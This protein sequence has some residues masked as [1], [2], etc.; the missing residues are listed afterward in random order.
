MRRI[1]ILGGGTAGTIMANRL[2]RALEPTRWE[3]VVIDGEPTHYYQPGFLFLPFGMYSRDDVV[4]P[5]L[6]FMPRGMKVVFTTAEAIEPADNRIHMADGSII[7][8]DYLIIATGSQVHPEETEGL[9]GEEWGHSIHEFYTLDGA[10]ALGELLGRWTGGRLVLNIAEMPIKCPVAPIEFLFLA[11]WWFTRR[12]MREKVELELVTPLPGAFTRPM[13]STVLGH[14]F[15]DKH[16]KLT[17]DFALAEVDGTAKQIKDWEGRSVAYDLLVSVPTN[18][19]DAVIARSGLGDD[20]NFVPT[21]P[22]TLQAKG[23]E[24]IYVLG[25][26]TDLPSSKAGSVAHFQSE[27]LT[28]NL[29]CAMRGAPPAASFDGHTN[30]FIESGYGK[31]ILVDFNY[32]TEP[33]PGKFPVPRLGPFTLLAESRINHWGKL[34]FRWIYWNLL[35]KGRSLLIPPRMSMAGKLPP[36]ALKKREA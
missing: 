36:P 24:N 30:C 14:M 1:V 7:E 20:L 34:G 16:I 2:H 31:A 26:A 13:C 8:Y 33:L 32:D 19:G 18:M 6:G 3:I 35:I 25:D 15:D 11:D 10:L 22:Q 29:L 28:E 23:Y 27:I 21:N 9:H 5:K 17:T 12:G 4:R